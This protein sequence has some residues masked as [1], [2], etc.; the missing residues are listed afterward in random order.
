MRMR[1]HVYGSL[2]VDLIPIPNC[3]NKVDHDTNVLLN[4]AI[5]AQQRNVGRRKSMPPDQS[6]NKTTFFSSPE[7]KAHG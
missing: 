2:W 4:T 5:P 3:T 6:V 1:T 7:S